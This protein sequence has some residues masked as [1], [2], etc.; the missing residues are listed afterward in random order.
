[1]QYKHVLEQCDNKAQGEGHRS[2]VV[3]CDIIV[4]SHEHI[5]AFC[6]IALEKPPKYMKPQFC[7]FIEANEGSM[8][9]YY[10]FVN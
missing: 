9:N 6:R 2:E 10:T 7:C 3:K 4:K 5:D 8:E 1:M